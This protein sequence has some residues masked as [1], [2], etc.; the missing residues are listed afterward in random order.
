MKMIQIFGTY[1][2][3]R[4]DAL[5]DIEKKSDEYVMIQFNNGYLIT[6]KKHLKGIVK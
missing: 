2:D 3:N 6:T 5:K 1:Y 4:E